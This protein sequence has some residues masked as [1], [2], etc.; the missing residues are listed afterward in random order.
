MGVT[1]DRLTSTLQRAIHGSLL[2]L[3]EL[4]KQARVDDSQLSRF[5]GNKRDLTLP[6]AAKLCAVLGLE[7]RPRKE[8]DEGKK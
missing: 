2:S 4:G 3:N 5:M 8:K 7:L 6:V 1:R